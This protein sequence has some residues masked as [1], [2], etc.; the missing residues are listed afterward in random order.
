MFVTTV[1]IRLS[2]YGVNWY[3]AL[4]AC[5][6][7]N[8]L[9]RQDSGCLKSMNEYLF[10]YGSL[11]NPTGLPEEIVE[12]ISTCRRCGAAKV[13]GRLYDFGAYSGAI[14][15]STTSTIIHGDLLAIPVDARLFDVLDRYEEIDPRNPADC[16]FA[17]RKTR[18]ELADGTIRE[19][20][21]Y[22]YNKPTGDAPLIEGGDYQIYKA[23]RLRGS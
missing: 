11:R 5:V 6:P 10:V 22:V 18:A 19:A 23:A 3:L 21:V 4:L 1:D 16:L 13:K 2:P 17:R 15:D 20:W 14:L 12:L 7:Q 9:A 8:R